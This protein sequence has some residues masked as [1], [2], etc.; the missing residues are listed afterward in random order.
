MGRAHPVA[1]PLAKVSGQM[2]D[3][4]S[5]LTQANL[6]ARGCL[7]ISS[8]HS[9]IEPDDLEFLVAQI[10]SALVHARNLVTRIDVVRRKPEIV[11]CPGRDHAPY[12]PVMSVP[13]RR[14]RGLG[15]CTRDED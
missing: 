12:S 2:A 11:A 4:V 5:K 6:A 10:E 15:F 9:A 8:N 1:D 3:L 13:T 14:D 7:Q